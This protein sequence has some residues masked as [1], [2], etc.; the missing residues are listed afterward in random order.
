MRKTLISLAA[1]LTLGLTAP[2]L[3]DATTAVD[4]PGIAMHGDTKYKSGFDHFDYANPDAPKGGVLHLGATGGFDSLNGFIIKGEAPEGLGLIYDTLMVSSADEAF[5]EYCLLC[6]R[7]V[8]PAD[9]SSV[10]FYM[11]TDAR[12]HDGKPVTVDDVIFTFETLRTKGSP[13]YR[14]YY[15]DVVKVEKVDGNGVRFTF[16]DSTNKELPLILGQLPVLPKHYWEGR[17]FDKTTQ[18]VPLGSG[19]YRVKE[20]EPGR[21]I[22]YERVA[23]YWGQNHP[24][25][26]GQ[27]NFGEIRYDFYLDPNVMFEAFKAGAIDYRVEN[28]SKLWATGY[29]LPAVRNG[30]MVKEEFPHHRNAGMQGFIMN[31]RRPLFQDVRVREALGFAFDFEWTNKNLF[32]GVYSRTES[33]FQNSE[34]AATGLPQGE[35]LEILKKLKEKY[36]DAVPDAVFTTPFKAP[37]NDGSGDARTNL[38]KA[39]DLLKAAGWDIPEGEFLLK[40]AAGETFRFEILLVSPAFERIMLPY[41]K[42]LRKLGMDVTVRTVDTSQYVNR[43][44]AFDFDMVVSG[45]GQSASPGN[46]Q[47]SMWTSEVVNVPES[48]NYAGI[49]NPAIDAAVDLLIGAPDRVSLVNRTRALDRLLQW[50]FYVVPNWHAKFDRLA[51]WDKFGHPSVTPDSGSD[52]YTWWIDAARDA[53]LDARKAAA[54]PKAN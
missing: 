7:V 54:A 29:D 17:T 9:R 1:V 25:R 36:P 13:H 53:T 23:D 28:T 40:N 8:V 48:S 20:F 52:I 31:M 6:E 33:Y 27:F 19:P 26:K 47:R 12:W 24:V 44:R 42:N 15:A 43:L 2:A 34:L 18:D 5:T 41:V 32:Y 30:A 14:F 50:G 37:V 45:W 46:E 4:G 49:A 3:A 21:Y 35:E 11:R 39:R 51:Y 38:V 16:K 10:T 22:V